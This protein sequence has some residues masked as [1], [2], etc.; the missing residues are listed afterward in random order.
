MRTSMVFRA[1]AAFLCS[2]HGIA[3]A[4]YGEEPHRPVSKVIDLLQGM[5]K[6]LQAE[7]EEDEQIYD[8]MACW[9]DTNDK[10]KTQAIADA[11]ARV[12]ELGTEISSLNAFSTQLSDE[13]RALEGDLETEQASLAQAS[14]IRTDQ[15][16]SFVA[17]EKD[18]TESITSLKAAIVVLSKH[19]EAF[20]QEHSTRFLSIATMVQ[21][22]LRCH[23]NLLRGVL[24]PSQRQKLNAFV[25]VHLGQAPK[26]QYE[27]QSGE[28]YGI[29]QE[30]LKT[31]ETDLSDA[32]KAEVEA[33]KVFLELK[34]TKEEQIKASQGQL[35]AKTLQKADTD[36]AEAQA[37]Q[38][39]ADT[40]ATLSADQQ[41]LTMVKDQCTL[42]DSEWK[43]RQTVRQEEMEAVTKALE[44]LSADD[45]H[46]TFTRTFNPSFLQKAITRD[47][48]MRSQVFTLL[49][50][51]AG[52][53]RNP[54]LASL[55][56]S[57]KLDNFTDVIHTIDNM[58][59][60][61]TKDT[62]DEIQHKDWCTKELNENQLETEK[63]EH[64]KDTVLAQIETIESS[65]EQL[66]KEIENL[67]QANEDM[68]LQLKR[69][70][71][72][73]ELENKEFQATIADQRETQRL[74]EEA[75]RFLNNFYAKEA[76]ASLV[77]KRQEPAGPP[78][79]A[80]FDTYQ[81]SKA[82]PGVIALID[83][84]LTDAKQVE[85]DTT[86][87]EE[88]SQKAYEDLVQE[89]NTA[90][91]A[92][93]DSIV[94]KQDSKAQAELQLGNEKA[95]RDSTVQELERLSSEA[96]DVHASCDFIL[97]NFDVRQTARDEE[98]EALR[99]A[100]AILSGSSER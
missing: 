32:Q 83:Q 61:L 47:F 27:A 31:F 93:E 91:G 17:E 81:N 82:A 92:N 65:I 53:R 26:P 16:A 51:V 10:E 78:Q 18:L 99:S 71:E 39:K 48:D 11:E 52:K 25:E 13:I 57:V 46:D 43:A 69:A 12:V 80:G 29:L 60:Q 6:T 14:Q 8:K 21:E 55:A 95:S 59:A 15:H 56:A 50:G 89:T 4:T 79:P 96:T 9:C 58:V 75:K 84:I 70:A 85:D 34:A 77:Q 97:K 54:K 42:T 49:A 68:N 22:Q 38:D 62:Q 7:Q 88:N 76:A 64:Q 66:A 20:L 86:R 87:A 24:T 28:I 37:K 35:D 1:M 2:V 44:V 36:S 19:Q 41:Y 63:Y 74:L 33:Q 73:R 94:N 45:A 5:L 67:K 98:I 30:M 40:Q 72:D 23:E 100:K 3:S 90:I